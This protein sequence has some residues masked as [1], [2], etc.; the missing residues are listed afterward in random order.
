MWLKIPLYIGYLHTTQCYP[1]PL[2]NVVK[3]CPLN[4]VRLLGFKKM[5][6]DAWAK[7]A[8]ADAL[9][10]YSKFVTAKI[11]N[12][13]PNSF[14]MSEPCQK[15]DCT[16]TKKESCRNVY[17]EDQ[18]VTFKRSAWAILLLGITVQSPWKDFESRWLLLKKIEINSLKL[19]VILFFLSL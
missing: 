19:R 5:S 10:L 18:N 2:V 4:C 14:E 9:Y 17:Y 7:V 1:P 6:Y 12:P 15:K 16:V 8:K 13:T 3:E 11:Y